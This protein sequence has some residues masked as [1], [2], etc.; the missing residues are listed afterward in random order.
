LLADAEPSIAV[1][2]AVLGVEPEALVLDA[3]RDA[4][5][6]FADSRLPASYPYT[7]RGLRPYRG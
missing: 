4:T 3:S 6:V 5:W 7:S 2:F 1:R